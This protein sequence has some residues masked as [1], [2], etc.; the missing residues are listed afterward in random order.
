MKQ[1]TSKAQKITESILKQILSGKLKPGGRIP[2]YDEMEK[3]YAVSRATLQQVI[4]KLK[5][6]GFVFSSG[7]RGTYISQ[8]PPHLFR[9]GI[10]FPAVERE[11]NRFWTALKN[12]CARISAGRVIDIVL[13]E[14]VDEH[15]DNA[16]Y[17]ELI[18]DIE[19]SRLAGLIFVSDP[20]RVVEAP[21]FESHSIPKVSIF[22]STRPDA[23]LVDTDDLSFL[24]KS[25]DWMK[26]R[27][28]SRIAV[29]SHPDQ[30][31]LEEFQGAVSKRGLKTNPYW[32]IPISLDHPETA[33]YVVGLLF[34]GSQEERPD[35]LIV[36][37]D[38]LVEYV[39]KALVGMDLR[40]PE[41]LEILVHCNWPWE[42]PSVLPV[43]RLG[44]DVRQIM[45]K[46]VDTIDGLRAGQT[47]PQHQ[48]IPATFEEDLESE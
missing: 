45:R 36:A 42:T 48:K 43:S 24:N 6:D 44:Y 47:I 39:Q 9:Y 20:H 15:V 19:S 14:D 26:K 22:E 27:N 35:G 31:V 5:R 18:Y 41:D 32:S 11:S 7:R 10:V 28:R 1:D 8:R 34:S 40:I 12:E 30:Q 23:Y 33:T 13:Y 2:T 29:I 25:L 17:Q 4:N 38:N 21:H 37:D 46:C 3:R 16:V